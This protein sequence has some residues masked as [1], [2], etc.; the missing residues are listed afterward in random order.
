MDIWD[1]LRIV[2]RRWKVAV[3]VFLVFGVFA[4]VG[5]GMVAAEYTADASVILLGPNQQAAGDTLDPNVASTDVNAYL[6]GCSSC[7]IVARA[8]QLALMSSPTM[9]SMAEQ[10][11]STDYS[12]TVENRSPIMLLQTSATSGSQATETLQG[13]I[14]RLN[15]ELESSQ[16]DVNAPTDQRISANVL[17]Q[18]EE[19][20]TSAGGRSRVRL[21]LLAVGAAVAVGAAFAVEGMA[22]KRGQRD[23]DEPAG[24]YGPY[25][26]YGDEG[27]GGGAHRP[28]H[29]SRSTNGTAVPEYPDYSVPAPQPARSY[30]S[31]PDAPASPYSSS[32]H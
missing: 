23:E 5:G 7:E 4:F 19:A 10:G 28:R 3:P 17:A 20:S 6:A 25:G 18:D 13:L 8:T 29:G 1:G 9:Q 30:D 22:Y 16:T 27:D 12:I 24:P 2:L 32:P 14:D 31:I 15:Q 11:L 21:A 26:D